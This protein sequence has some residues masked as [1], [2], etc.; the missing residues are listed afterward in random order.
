M[1][2]RCEKLK[3]ERQM[4]D[5]D[6]DV[7]QH[8]FNIRRLAIF[9]PL[10][11]LPILFSI[12]AENLCLMCSIV[13]DFC[14]YGLCFRKHLKCFSVDYIVVRLQPTALAKTPLGQSSRNSFRLE[15]NMQPT[16]ATQPD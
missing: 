12:S 11:L 4:E 3:I 8:T 6:V 10:L 15:W 1:E 7:T 13:A 14:I 16:P 5:N 9:V 2:K